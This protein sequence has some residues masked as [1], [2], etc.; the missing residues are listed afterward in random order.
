MEKNAKLKKWTSILGKGSQLNTS[1]RF[2]PG[3]FVE[4]LQIKSSKEFIA[5]SFRTL[6]HFSVGQTLASVKTIFFS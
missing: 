3:S 5:F 4:F 6:R 1:T 2:K